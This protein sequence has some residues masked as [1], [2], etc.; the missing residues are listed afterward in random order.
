MFGVY[1]DTGKIE[2]KIKLKQSERRIK[3]KKQQLGLLE[4]TK[5]R[6]LSS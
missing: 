2:L 3:A 1:D 5:T 4:D 6:I